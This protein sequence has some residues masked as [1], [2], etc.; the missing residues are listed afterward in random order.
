[1]NRDIPMYKRKFRNT[2][3]YSVC[4]RIGIKKSAGPTWTVL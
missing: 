2:H 4:E 1:M 3:R